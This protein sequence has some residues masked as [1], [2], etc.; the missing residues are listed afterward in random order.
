MTG[1][2][3]DIPKLLCP[4]MLHVGFVRMQGDADFGDYLP[5]LS[6]AER[7]RAQS[8]SNP[9]RRRVYLAGHALL[10]IVLSKICSVEPDSLPLVFPA[11][12]APRL[13]NDYCHFSLS[14][15]ADTLMLGISREGPIGVDLQDIAQ[16]EGREEVFRRFSTKLEW[17]IISKGAPA[18]R[19]LDCARLWT[20]KEAIAKA[21]GT[22]LRPSHAEMNSLGDQTVGPGGATWFLYDIP[23]PSGGVAS[24][25]THFK[26]DD[27]RIYDWGWVLDG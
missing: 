8:L 13:E 24:A 15:T 5:V 27:I 6:P 2:V 7:N 3:C 21:E 11:K 10:R 14:H 20:R 12:D 17:E 26:A 9:A 22:G 23:C 18:Q 25:A 1:P 16:C 4:D 19:R